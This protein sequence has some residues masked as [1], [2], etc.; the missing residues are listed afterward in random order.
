MWSWQAMNIWSQVT[1]NDFYICQW[2]RR[3]RTNGQEALKERK[4][5]VCRKSHIDLHDILQKI[6]GEINHHRKILGNKYQNHEDKGRHID[7]GSYPFTH[8]VKGGE[9]ERSK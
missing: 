1:L 2:I 5:R 8:D 3:G 6:Q 7:K 4:G 9:R